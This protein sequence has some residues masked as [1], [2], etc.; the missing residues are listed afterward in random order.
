MKEQTV[1]SAESV[2][3]CVLGALYPCLVINVCMLVH[4]IVCM[5]VCLSFPIQ[6]ACIS[7]FKSSSI[8]GNR[9]R[10]RNYEMIFLGLCSM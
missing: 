2:Y 4:Y 7:F 6:N 5:R 9:V 1:A 3:V 10:N 8:L